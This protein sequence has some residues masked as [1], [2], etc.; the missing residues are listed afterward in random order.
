MIEKQE[1]KGENKKRL[2][3]K[4][5]KI[6]KK[7]KKHDW[8]T[9]QGAWSTS[10]G[11]N[12]R[13]AISCRQSATYRACPWRSLARHTCKQKTLKKKKKS[14]KSISNFMTKTTRKKDAQKTKVTTT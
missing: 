7:K 1:K 9:R 4:N 2:K 11:W 6:K 3:K 14:N 10:G 12:R 8:G 13:I 5:E